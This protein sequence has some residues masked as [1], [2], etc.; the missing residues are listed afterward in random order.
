MKRYRWLNSAQARTVQL[1]FSCGPPGQRTAA[2]RSVG[3]SNEQP[4]DAKPVDQKQDVIIPSPDDPRTLEGCENHE[5]GPN[6]GQTASGPLGTTTHRGNR[7]GWATQ[8][9]LGWGGGGLCVATCKGS[10]PTNILCGAITQQTSVF[11]PKIASTA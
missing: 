9:S 7:F 1:P 8:P 2:C 5:R 11:E 6:P 10:A 4:H 3:A